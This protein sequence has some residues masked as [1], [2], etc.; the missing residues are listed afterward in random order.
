MSEERALDADLARQAAAG[1]LGALAQ[2]VNKHRER[3]LRTAQ[4]IVGSIQE[5]DDIAQEV[6]IKV[7]RHLPGFHGPEVFTSWLY[8][9]TVNTALDALRRRPDETPLESCHEAPESLEDTAL[10]NEQLQRLRVA[11]EALPPAIRATL[12]LREY[13]QLS[14]KEIADVLQVPI[15]TVMSRLSYGRQTLRRLCSLETRE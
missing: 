10:R 6:F 14:Y 9:I 5:A 15:G 1:N 8:R 3:V 11:I 12:V 4:G 13:E 2:L 7:W